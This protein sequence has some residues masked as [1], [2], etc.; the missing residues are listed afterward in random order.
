MRWLL[1]PILIPW[2][3]VTRVIRRF[4]DER[5]AQTSAALSFAT[6]LGLVPMFA[7]GAAIVTRLPF[8]SDLGAALEK[9]LLANLLPDKAG[10]VIAKYVGQFA[11]RAERVTLLGGALLAITALMQ[12]L[13]IE[14]AFNAIWKVGAPRPWLKRVAMHLMALLLG[15]LVFGGS[16]IATTYLASVSFGVVG[17][18]VWVNTL[19]FK[20]LPI[21]FMTALFALVYWAIPNRVIRPWHALTGGLL[22]GLGFAMLQRLFSLFVAQLPTYTVIYGAFAAMPVFLIWLYASWGLILTGALVTAELPG[23]FSAGT[24]PRKAKSRD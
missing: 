19:F 17:E 15:P 18:P 20:T 1:A 21:A 16:L 22:A 13:T 5:C 11:H 9:F 7:V 23:V 14:H 6:L 24:S 2:R 4:D 12:M 10:T 8:G 3:L